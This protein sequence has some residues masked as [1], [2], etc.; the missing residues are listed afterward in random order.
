MRTLAS[1][2]NIIDP[3][4]LALGESFMREDIPALFGEAYNPG[5]WNVGHVVL[6][7]RPATTLVA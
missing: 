6:G 5:N 2:R 4:D 7:K 1:L 3:L